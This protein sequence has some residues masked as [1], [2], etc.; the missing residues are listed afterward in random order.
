MLMISR[1]Y[2]PPFTPVMSAVN[3]RS[4]QTCG[5]AVRHTEWAATASAC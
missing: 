3:M 5:F 4:V 1:D 2:F